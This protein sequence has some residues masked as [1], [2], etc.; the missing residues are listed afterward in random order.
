MCSDVLLW[1]LTCNVVFTIT[2]YFTGGGF[3][4]SVPLFLCLLIVLYWSSYWRGETSSTREGVIRSSIVNSFYWIWATDKRLILL[5][6]VFSTYRIVMNINNPSLEAR[7]GGA[8]SLILFTALICLL[9][10]LPDKVMLLWS[11]IVQSRCN[12]STFC[13]FLLSSEMFLT[14][15]LFLGVCLAYLIDADIIKVVQHLMGMPSCYPVLE[16]K[17]QYS[18]LLPAN[19]RITDHWNASNS[20]PYMVVMLRNVL[21]SDGEY[22]GSM[23]TF[24]PTLIGLYLVSRLFLSDRHSV[25]VLTLFYMVQAACVAGM[26]S[27][28]LKHSSHRFRPTA[29]SSPYVWLGPGHRLSLGHGYSGLD[30]SFPSGH[31]TVTTAVASVILFSIINHFAVSLFSLVALLITIY[32]FSFLVMI[33]RIS[34]CEHWPSDVLSGVRVSWY[35]LYL[36]IPACIFYRCC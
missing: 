5:L 24:L 22:L 6:L 26:V 17:P 33:N 10:V 36:F 15:I 28:A 16:T 13:S 29:F 12:G 25:I 27:A 34:H 4:C 30:C 11:Y 9:Y 3:V 21:M 2:L 18:D 19:Q 20:I 1:T 31:A 35:H 14:V 8:Y 32:W 23:N 7:K